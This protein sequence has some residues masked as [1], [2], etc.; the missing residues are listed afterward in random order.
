VTV[1]PPGFVDNLPVFD[2]WSV[3][4]PFLFPIIEDAVDA[5]PSEERREPVLLL[6]PSLRVVDILL[7]F[8]WW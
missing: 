8:L 6:A 4:D 2:E 3:V 1:G 7:C 5:A